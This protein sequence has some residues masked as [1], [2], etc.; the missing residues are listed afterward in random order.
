MKSFLYATIAVITSLYIIACGG[1]DSF[2]SDKFFAL[3]NGPVMV[4]NNEL[5]QNVDP[6]TTVVVG[7]LD[8]A[9]NSNAQVSITNLETLEQRIVRSNNRGGFI[10]TLTG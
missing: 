4:L 8:G 10:A 5:N 9:V 3:N 7:G 6:N 2:D 1:S